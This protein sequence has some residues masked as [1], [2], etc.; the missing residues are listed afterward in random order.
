M[1]R[2]LNGKVAV[3]TGGSKG[4]GAGIA[5][6]FG[7]E[8]MA[9]VINYLGDHEGA[10]KTADTVIKNGGQAVSIHADVSTEAGI[11]SLVKT[12]ESEFGRLDVW[13]NNAGMEI[14][15]PTHEVS[16]DDWNKVIAINQTGVFLGA[17]AALNYFLDHHQPGNIINITSVHEQIPWPTFASYTAAKGAV[18]LFTETIA[19]EYANRRIR[20]NAIGH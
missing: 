6:R 7:K 17:R 8:H 16:L 19:M 4:I 14:K 20:V 2:D 18:K 10:R 15:A 3:V 9:V 11:A 5:E 13:V 1:Y 12:A